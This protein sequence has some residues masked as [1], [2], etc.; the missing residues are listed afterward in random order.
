MRHRHPQQVQMEVLAPQLSATQ[1][2]CAA[3]DDSRCDSDLPSDLD[4]QLKDDKVL[5]CVGM[6]ALGLPRARRRPVPA[7]HPLQVLQQSAEAPQRGAVCQQQEMKVKRA[8]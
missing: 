7:P 4:L 8:R 3:L 6:D 5:V 2:I 1:H